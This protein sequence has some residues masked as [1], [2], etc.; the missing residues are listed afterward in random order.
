MAV[1]GLVLSLSLSRAQDQSLV[2]E[3]RSCKPQGAAKKSF[4]KNKIKWN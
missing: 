2:R 3:L 4:E 1:Q